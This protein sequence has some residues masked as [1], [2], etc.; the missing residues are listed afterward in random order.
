MSS[1]DERLDAS[2]AQLAAAE[3]DAV[4]V[5]STDRYLNE[6]VPAEDSLRRWL[7]GFTGSMGEALVEA[8]DARL[9]VDGRYWLQAETQAPPG[10][11]VARVPLGQTLDQ[12]MIAHLGAEKDTGRVSRLGVEG[13]RWTVEEV[14]ALRAALGSDV[15]VRVL[16]PSPIDAARRALNDGPPESASPN[17]RAVAPERLGTTAAERL[18]ALFA[19]VPAEVA[20][21][22]IHRLDDIAY[23]SGLRAQQ[24]PYQSTFKS[25]AVA[26][27]DGL[28]V[29]L[30]SPTA[31]PRGLDPSVELMSEAELWSWLEGG[32]VALLGFDPGHTVQSVRDRWTSAGLASV[33]VKTTLAALKAKKSPA[34]LSVMREAFSRADRVVAAT[35]RWAVDAFA[36]DQTVTEGGFRDELERRF[37]E[38]GAHGQSFRTIA[39]AGENGAII[40]YGDAG[41]RPLRPGE[42]ML[43]DCGAYFD[44]G[45]ATDLTRT[46]LVGAS[47]AVADPEQRRLYTTVLK[48]AIAG[49]TARLP[50]GVTGGQLDAIVRAPL[51]A[52][53]L[54]YAHGTGHGVGINV[55]EFPPRVG[56]GHRSVLEPGMVFS[57]EPG[58]YIPDYGG[59][60]IENLCTIEPAPVDG[61]LDVR[62]LTFCPLDARL[63]DR[64]RLTRRERAFLDGFAKVG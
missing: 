28:R 11:T 41:A 39:A 9:F 24:L 14:D 16:S 57:I 8:D 62:P 4:W 53:G 49:M 7:T 22:W 26:T 37:A 40:H 42:L 17:L 55:H 25:V 63:I 6:Y 45:Y 50:V 30:E 35:I 34:E 61:F 12:A 15:E 5:R 47:D 52:E 3:V 48:A 38:A 60:R 56:P 64:E 13:D 43:V 27:R 58:V 18:S 31:P 20:G 54:D 46:F 33:S 23:L 29:G 19:G 2:R 21:L 1:A 44:E 36:T 10:W 51:W 59:I 32:G